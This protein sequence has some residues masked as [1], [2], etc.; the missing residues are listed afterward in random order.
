MWAM[1]IKKLIWIFLIL[2]LSS[3]KNHKIC[4]S[5]KLKSIN[6][7]LWEIKFSN[8]KYDDEKKYYDKKN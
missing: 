8:I 4:D 7:S 2:N 6:F 3:L 1:I 5:R